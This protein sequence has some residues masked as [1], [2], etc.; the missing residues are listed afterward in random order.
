MNSAT[1]IF[2]ARIGKRDE[3]SLKRLCSNYGEVSEVTLLSEGK[4]SKACGFVKFRR[5]ADAMKC[6]SDAKEHKGVFSDNTKI[7]VEW[8][9]SSQ[10]K[11]CDLDKT[12]LFING[13]KTCDEQY[14][15][16][17]LSMYG[18]IERVT[19]PRGEQVYAFVKFANTESASMAKANEDGK[20]WNGQQVIIEY[21]EAM[22]SKRMRRQK[23]TMKMFNSF[24]EHI[25]APTSPVL[26]DSDDSHTDDEETSQDS[27]LKEDTHNLLREIIDWEAAPAY[28]ASPMSWDY[29]DNE[30]PVFKEMIRTHDDIV[31]PSCIES[32]L[33]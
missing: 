30:L 28:S 14:I 10:I 21:S 3:A 27:Y 5:V 32:L 19:I 9:K 1:T 22:S 23:A 29:D 24:F 15:R 31:M 26:Q 12:T 17:K 33:H 7:V 2:V 4:K 13:M 6:V 16:S 25:S 20:Y 8:A 18:L 11:D